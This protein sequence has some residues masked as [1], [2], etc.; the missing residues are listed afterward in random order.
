MDGGNKACFRP[1]VDDAARFETDGLSFKG[2]IF[3]DEW[4]ESI[5]IVKGHSGGLT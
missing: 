2:G 1:W 3:L 5:R 4:G